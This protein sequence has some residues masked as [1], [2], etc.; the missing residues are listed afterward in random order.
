MK[1]FKI[2]DSVIK[3]YELKIEAIKLERVKQ[4]DDS[5]LKES[6]QNLANKNADIRIFKKQLQDCKDGICPTCKKDFYYTRLNFRVK[7]QLTAFVC[8]GFPHYTRL[9]FRV[10]L[11]QMY[12]SVI[13]CL[14]YTRLNFRV[15]LQQY[16]SERSE[17][18]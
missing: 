9:N 1:N 11:Q 6:K 14:H 4:F 5:L 7:L 2:D 10:K 3:D 15:K 16:T 13:L 8:A 17:R 18:L 12:L